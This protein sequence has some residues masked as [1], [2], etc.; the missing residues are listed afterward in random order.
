[1]RLGERLV[2]EQ[3]LGSH[4]LDV[5]LRAQ[6]IYGGRLGTNLVE[7]GQVALDALTLALAEQTGVPAALQQHFEQIDP[8]V[9][10]LI[11]PEI[12]EKHHAIPL[13][14][15]R[16]AGPQ[17]VVAFMDPHQPAALQ[18]IGELAQARVTPC[19]APE[20]RLHFYLEHFYGI[21]R[22]N[23]FLRIAVPETTGAR[24]RVGQG[25]LA[26]RRRYLG[27]DEET[28]WPSAGL[29]TLEGSPP[30]AAPPLPAPRTLTADDAQ[31]AI[32]EATTRDEIGD[33]IVDHLRSAYGCG[34]VL[35]DRDGLGLGWKGFSPA[36]DPTI[37][38][39][40]AVPLSAPSALRTAHE[41]RGIFRGEPPAD[42]AAGVQTRLWKLLRVPPPPEVVVAPVVL[43]GRVVC[44]VLALPHPGAPLP[45]PAAQDLGALVAT[46]ATAFV[47]LIQRAKQSQ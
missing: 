20:L 16:L 44:L 42:G 14:L 27:A 34:V 12:A 35:V 21:R 4:E 43:G 23:R 37:I 41:A 17:L 2:H 18:E 24:P 8:H 26:E 13:G 47:R 10:R 5:A 3:R 46:A 39:A 29:A 6:V 9:L 33:A 19:V 28:P 1:M 45:E 11:T 15:A 30:P 38:E 25:Y 32:Q 40:I 36:V 31:A 7:L 22:K